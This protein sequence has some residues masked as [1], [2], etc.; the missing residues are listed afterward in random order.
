[1][2]M[3][4]AVLPAVVLLR[5][6]WKMDTIETE[7]TDLLAKLFVGGGLSIISAV[8]LG[9]IGSGVIL[10]WFIPGSL[11]YIFLD[12]F[13]CTA[14]VEE[15][16]KYFVLKKL[17]W[18]HPAFDYTF[19]AVVYAVT[20]ALGFA[21]LENILYVFEGGIGTAIFRAILSVPGHAIDGVFMGSYYGLAKL[22]EVRGEQQ[23]RSW[24]L[25]LALLV[26]TL[27]HGFYDFCLESG[28]DFLLLAFLVFEIVITITAIRRLKKLA[29]EDQPIEREETPI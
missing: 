27:M 2:L 8:V 20:A 23:G 13:V 11:I 12:N 29:R 19:D 25:R 9:M 18:N 14:L 10:S 17:T 16:G 28:N 22:C 26:P 1:M 7:P 4:L 3:L 5:M 6:V 24:H 21:T 15:G